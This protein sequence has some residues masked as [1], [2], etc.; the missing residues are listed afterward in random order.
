VKI[1]FVGKGNAADVLADWKRPK[2]RYGARCVNFCCLI[3]LYVCVFC[4]MSLSP[5]SVVTNRP[6]SRAMF[7]AQTSL[8]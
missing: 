6:T 7:K 3:L 1:V 5:C 2:Q 8:L 4:S